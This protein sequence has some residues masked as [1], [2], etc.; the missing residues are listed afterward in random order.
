MKIDKNDDG[1]VNQ[2]SLEMVNKKLESFVEIILTK[3]TDH[4]QEIRKLKAQIKKL[5]KA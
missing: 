3:L 1:T 4:Q 2:V 5:E